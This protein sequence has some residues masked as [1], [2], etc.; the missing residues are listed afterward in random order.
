MCKCEVYFL[1]YVKEVQVVVIMLLMVMGGFCICVG[2]NDVLV[3]GEVDLIGFGC[4]FCV[5]VDVLGQLCVGEF[6]VLLKWEKFL[7]IGLGIFGLNFFI[8]LFKVLNGFGMQGWFYIQL[9]W[10][11]DGDVLNCKF[12]VFSV[13]LKMQGFDLKMVKVYYVDFVVKEIV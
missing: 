11:V 12:G 5:D 4:L 8:G 9:Y 13:F 7:W 1:E 10:I 3:V 6:E 2:M